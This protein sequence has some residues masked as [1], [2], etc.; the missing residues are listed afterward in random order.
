MNF[1]ESEIEVITKLFN[2]LKDC[3]LYRGEYD[4]VNGSE[5]FMYG[6]SSVMESIAR[7]IS[8][9]LAEEHCAH[10]IHNMLMS[11]LKMARDEFE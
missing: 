9:D 7:I 4:A 2:H 11:E 1:T 3:P 6:V 5:S 8:D 10:F